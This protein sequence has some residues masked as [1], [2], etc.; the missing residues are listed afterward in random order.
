MRTWALGMNGA[1]PDSDSDGSDSGNS[2]SDGD[3]SDDDDCDESDIKD[4]IDSGTD[5]DGTDPHYMPCSETVRKRW[6]RFTTAW[7]RAHNPPLPH[8]IAD[9]VTEVCL[10]SSLISSCSSLMSSISTAL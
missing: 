6:N 4:G 7:R 1:M 2:D 10:L 8:D 3:V 9:S 5:D